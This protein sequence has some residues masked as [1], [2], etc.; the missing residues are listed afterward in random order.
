M[1]ENR[2]TVFIGIFF[3]G[4]EFVLNKEDLQAIN[5]ILITVFDGMTDPERSGFPLLNREKVMNRV[6]K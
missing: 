5:D 2:K 1:R 6:R 3:D 4:Q